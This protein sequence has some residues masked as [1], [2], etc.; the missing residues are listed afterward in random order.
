MAG[1]PNGRSSTKAKV[2]KDTTLWEKHPKL[3][4]EA[5]RARGQGVG[6]GHEQFQLMYNRSVPYPAV[7][8]SNTIYDIPR[9]KYSWA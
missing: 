2:I 9:Y 8:S 5:Q 3:T 7:K 1:G 6:K 4:N